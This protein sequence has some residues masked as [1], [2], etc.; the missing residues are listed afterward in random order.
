[1]RAIWLENRKVFIKENIPAP[2]CENDDALVRVIMAGICN[3]DL[4]MAKGYYPFTGIL[5]HEFVG[6]VVESP[7]PTLVGSRV[8]GEI[9]I[10]C[11]KCVNCRR[12]KSN[13]CVNRTTLGIQKR[14]GCFAEYLSL[15]LKNLHIIPENLSDEKA[16]FTEPLAA[17]LQ[18][19]HQIHI[20]SSNKVLVVGAG[21]LG[22]LIAQ[23]I[24]LT[25]CKLQVVVR[26]SYQRDILTSINIKTV[27]ERQVEEYSYDIV[28][29]ATGSS[30][31]FNLA[32]SAVQPGG[33]IVLKSTFK[34]KTSLNLS[35]LVVDE[36]TVVGSRCGPY[37]PALK[38][39]EMGHVDPTPLISK[40][41]RLA[42]GLLALDR[43]AQPG[44]LKILLEN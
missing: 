17:A 30:S 23:T 1:M 40:R 32:R 18:I 27:T 14:H 29:D 8:T 25:G 16:V 5:G 10:T 12:G 28:V 6:E 44:M 9:N 42:D 3:T 39:L 33:I 35:S 36:V 34:G 15:P 41:Y 31:G 7:D 43:A 37:E 38:L 4:E 26:H 21:R 11:G 20:Q 24:S 22:L 2:K 13:H 19:Q